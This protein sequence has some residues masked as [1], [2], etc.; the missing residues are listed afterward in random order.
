MTA[1]R[2][3]L[4]LPFTLAMSFSLVSCAEDVRDLVLD[5]RGDA[6]AR[7]TSVPMSCTDEGCACAADS[8]PVDCYLDA[9]F[10]DGEM[11]CGLGRRHCRGGALSA[12][13]SIGQI[14]R[15]RVKLISPPATCN[16]CDPGCFTSIAVLDEADLDTTTNDNVRFDPSQGGIVIDT[17]AGGSGVGADSDGDGIP[18]ALDACDSTPDAL[19]PCGVP[20]DGIVHVL[21]FEGPVEY[22]PITIDFPIQPA[23]IY[24]LMDGTGSMSEE[25]AQL[26]N[27]LG[28]VTVSPCAPGQGL[29]GAIRCTIPDADFG[30]GTFQEFPGAGPGTNEAG[31]EFNVPYHHI[32]D[33]AHDLDLARLA[34]SALYPIDNNSRPESVTQALYATVT[35]RGIGRYF[36]NRTS[37]PAGRTGYACFRDEA[38]P[39]IVLF[40]DA[41]FHQ[42]PV[43]DPSYDYVGG[44]FRDVSWSSAVVPPTISAIDV[45]SENVASSVHVGDL[46]ATYGSFLLSTRAMNGDVTTSCG[47]AGDRDAV[48]RFSLSAA[49][50]LSLDTAGSSTN[51]TLE[52]R[53]AGGAVIA[54]NTDDPSTGLTY[55]SRVRATLPA[56][57]YQLV[58]DGAPMPVVRAATAP[59]SPVTIRVDGTNYS[60][61]HIY[62]G[63]SPPRVESGAI[64]LN[65]RARAHP[66]V[67]DHGLG[68][69][70]ATAVH[71]GTV[72]SAT[73]V[74][75][76]GSTAFASHDATPSCSTVGFGGPPAQPDRFHRFSVAAPGRLTVTTHGSGFDTVVAVLDAG[77]TE[78][79]CN[80]DSFAIADN[81]LSRLTVQLPAAGTYY[82]LVDG[83]VSERRFD[84]NTGTLV[85]AE[86][87]SFGEYRVQLSLEDGLVAGR[88]GDARAAPMDLGTLGVG[89]HGTAG[90]SALALP[91]HTLTGCG[92]TATA[93]TGV[94]NDVV[95]AFTLA[96]PASVSLSTQGST[97]GFD[98]VLGLV[99]AAGVEIGCSDDVSA[100]DRTSILTTGV[101]P[102]GRYY[103]VVDGHGGKVA[104]DVTRGEYVLGIHVAS[105]SATPPPSPRT[106][107]TPA[108]AYDLGDLTNRYRSIGGS[109]IGMVANN[110]ATWGTGGH[111]SRPDVAFRFTLTATTTISIDTR[112]STVAGSPYTFDTHLAL[113][114]TTGTP[115]AANVLASNDNDTGLGFSPC[116]G[117]DCARLSRIVRTLGPG[118]YTVLLDG[119][120][121]SASSS[122]QGRYRLNI[123]NAAA[124]ATRTDLFFGD[125]VDDGFDLGAID[126]RTIALQVPSNAGVSSAIYGCET[127]SSGDPLV[128]QGNFPDFTYRFTLSEAAT[129]GVETFEPPGDAIVAISRVDSGAFVH[130]ADD[131]GPEVSFTRALPAGTYLLHVKA[132]GP[133]GQVLLSASSSAGSTTP[134]D[135]ALTVASP[136]FWSDVVDAV[137]AAGVH[138]ITVSSC[139]T[140]PTYADADSNYD[141][142]HV[143]DSARALGFATGTVDVDGNPIVQEIPPNTSSGDF[144][145]VASAVLDGVERF[146]EAQRFDLDVRCRDVTPTNGI[147]ECSFVESMGAD[148][149]CPATRCAGTSPTGCYDCLPSTGL[150]FA[151]RFRN[152][153]FPPAAT[154]QFYELA[155]EV[156]R[157]GDGVVRSVPVTIG[158]PPLASVLHESGVFELDYDT[159]ERCLAPSQRPFW[160]TL[161]IDAAVPPE[162]AMRVEIVAADS[163]AGLAGAAELTFPI[164]GSGV[165]E[166]DLATSLASITPPQPYHLRARVILEADETYAISP[167]LRGLTASF[168]CRDVE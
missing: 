34:V 4:L 2:R 20:D 99:D 156:V 87:P 104:S 167:I 17:E 53:D 81:D 97:A 145:V 31:N 64:R 139:G 79:G 21:P 14:T 92:A 128:S 50:E 83:G 142:V 122:G 124:A 8:E 56:G 61:G 36:G 149:T 155:I 152:D 123:G 96:A 118:T 3:L 16:P 59:F 42:G 102:A 153:A 148:P 69:T 88:L 13:E 55:G 115:T 51:V 117:S 63:G 45:L 127:D 30:F 80:D 27:A 44:T 109:T 66:L 72:T 82:V 1:R 19:P 28:F 57:D 23:D 35:G 138:V 131:G 94:S 105:T 168:T 137:V 135:P 90:N 12:C 163:E 151:V 74:T 32:L 114:N 147:D 119:G 103:V 54:C 112:G 76:S 68:D 100:T 129:V 62:G 93:A 136:V 133:G 41:M 121:S 165:T 22:D 15:S 18:D 6:G 38:V 43:V 116:S 160:S 89:F 158:V 154:W 84:S 108:S 37:C 91:D 10:A 161:E 11:I 60:S 107:E 106:G 141:C 130:C 111:T 162:T 71:A 126:G 33:I 39:V 46:S 58:V 7:D 5:A 75:L 67:A 134:T 166:I 159:T 146:A 95:Y 40:T 101:L 29:L 125:T 49:T 132:D 98:T 24:V 48:L 143:R 26:R 65:V 164:M 85:I 78:I 86:N 120:A 144:V 140:P 25:M 113:L 52:L 110:T 9:R 70:R 47:G 77:G 73:P 157:E 150:P